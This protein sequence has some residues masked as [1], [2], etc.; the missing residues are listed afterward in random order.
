MHVEDGAKGWCQ[1]MHVYILDIVPVRIVSAARRAGWPRESP[2]SCGGS[3][4]FAHSCRHGGRKGTAAGPCTAGLTPGLVPAPGDMV[5]DMGTWCRSM[6]ID[7]LDAVFVRIVGNSPTLG[8]C[9]EAYCSR[10]RARRLCG[11][12][13]PQ[14]G[15][16]PVLNANMLIA[17]CDKL[18]T[19]MDRPQPP[20]PLSGQAG[21]LALQLPRG[22]AGGEINQG[23]AN[24]RRLT[25]NVHGPPP[26]MDRPQ[27][28]TSTPRRWCRPQPQPNSAHRHPSVSMH[29]ARTAP[30]VTSM[31][32][33][34]LL[35]PVNEKQAESSEPSS[36]N[37]I[38]PDPSVLPAQELA[39]S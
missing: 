39:S 3:A 10:T 22:E 15:R 18:S 38:S 29:S 14:L 16:S 33:P 11:L 13:L 5:P 1:S 37:V 28:P 34:S 32:P 4:F 6:H 12:S 36:R 19:C 26:T 25:V 24:S 2:E 17:A 7:I 9:V 23:A 20:Q 31:V 27:P 30:S 21:R 35:V 8:G